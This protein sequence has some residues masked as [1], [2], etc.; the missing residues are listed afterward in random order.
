[1]S[2]TSAEVYTSWRK[3]KELAE[4]ERLRTILED[5]VSEWTRRWKQCV[6]YC[7]KAIVFGSGGEGEA[8]FR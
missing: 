3:K 5:D 6:F 8:G 7:E 4:K 2:S 1:V